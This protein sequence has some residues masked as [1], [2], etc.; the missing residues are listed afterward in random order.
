MPWS[1][2]DVPKA[3]AIMQYNLAV[4]HAIRGEYEKALD[5]LN[6]V[7]LLETV[8]SNIQITSQVINN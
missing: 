3:Q 5:L 7:W 8:V 4:C 1:P 2:Q 6:K